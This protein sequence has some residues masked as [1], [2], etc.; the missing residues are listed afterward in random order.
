MRRVKGKRRNEDKGKRMHKVKDDRE[1][2]KGGERI[3]K[4]EKGFRY[5]KE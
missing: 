5:R 4:K 3:S 1:N 2:E